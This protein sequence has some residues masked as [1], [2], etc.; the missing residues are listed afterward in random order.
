MLS[1]VEN[2]QDDEYDTA[3]EPTNDVLLRHRIGLAYS[4]ALFKGR[5]DNVF[6]LKDYIAG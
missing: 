2:R 5:M 3:F 1:R 4:Q 6:F